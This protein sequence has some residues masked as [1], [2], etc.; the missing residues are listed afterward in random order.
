MVNITATKGDI[1]FNK[2]VLNSYENSYFDFLQSAGFI[3]IDKENISF[4][5]QSLIDA[6]LAKN[7][8]RIYY[9]KEDSI[10]TSDIV[11]LKKNKHL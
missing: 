5:H 10:V 11:G 8:V 3:Y 6:F 7:M 4:V 9:E 1:T 2:V